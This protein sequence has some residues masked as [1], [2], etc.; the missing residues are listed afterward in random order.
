MRQQISAKP[1]VELQKP[2]GFQVIAEASS[3]ITANSFKKRQSGF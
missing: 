1:A 2:S 3:Q